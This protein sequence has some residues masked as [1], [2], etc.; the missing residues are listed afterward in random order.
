MNDPHFDIGISCPKSMADAILPEFEADLAGGRFR[1]RTE[2]T[3]DTQFFASSKWMI[4]TAIAVYLA[5][6]YF[7]TILQEA[8]KDHY[9]WLK[10]AFVRLVRKAFGTE[11]E[12]SP[13]QVSELLSVYAETRELATVKFLI[14]EGHPMAHYECSL[15]QAHELLIEHYA[16][17]PNDSLTAK[18]ASVRSRTTK[19]L[20]YDTASGEWCPVDPVPETIRK[21]GES[22]NA[23][24]AGV[25]PPGG[26]S[27][28]P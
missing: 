1:V 6:P 11:P 7:E 22:E 25:P 13:R 19:L 9:K 12:E 16:K 3:E 10:A 18:M 26:H 27:S 28:P 21:K 4:P 17:H 8:A 5:K 20:L 23:P 2:I 14:E 15:E 24:D